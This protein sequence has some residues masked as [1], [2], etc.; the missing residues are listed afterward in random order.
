MNGAFVHRFEACGPACALDP[1][2]RTRRSS[3]LWASSCAGRRRANP[4]GRL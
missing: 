2:F 4:G 3:G 1:A